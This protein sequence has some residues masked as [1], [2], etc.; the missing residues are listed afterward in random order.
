[1]VVVRGVTVVVVVGWVGDGWGGFGIVVVVVVVLVLV[2]LV[3]VG[4]GLCR[5]GLT[6]LARLTAGL[7]MVVVVCTGAFMHTICFV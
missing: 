4:V 3:V 2:V 7:I 5:L 1:V 6:G